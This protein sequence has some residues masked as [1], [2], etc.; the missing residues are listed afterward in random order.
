ML[1]GLRKFT[2]VLC[3]ILSKLFCVGQNSIVTE[4]LLPGN[5]AS[6]WDIQ[7][8]GDLS[9]QGFASTISVNKGEKVS[10]KVKTAAAAYT[11]K[12]YRLGFYQG[13]GARFI[14]TAVITASLPQLQPADLYDTATGMIDCGN[15]SVSAHWDVPVTAVSGIYIAKLTRNDTNGSSHIAFIVRDD[16]ANADILFKTADATWQAYNNYGGNSLYVNN[17]GIA[18]PGFNHA[19]KVS[20]NRPFYT[21]SGGG[22]G[23]AMED[24]LFNAEYPM[25][26]WLERNGYHVSYTTDADMDSLAEIITPLKHK[27]LLSVGH[28]EYWSA[29]MRSA[30]SNARNAGVHLAFFSGNEVY[31]KTRWGNNHRTLVCYKE[32]TQGE[33]VCGGKCDPIADVWTGLWR[34][35][36]LFTGADGCDAENA[37]TGQISW[38]GSTTS[39]QVP[40]V[41]GKHRFWRNTTVA[42]ASPGTTVTFPD[43]T[44][45]YE[46]DWEQQ[47]FKS[48]NPS[49]RMLLSSTT[50][51]GRTHKLSLYRHLSGALV[52][53]AGTVQWS[54]G[55]DN[56]HD[57]GN[58]PVSKDMQQ[59]TVNLLADMNV[60]PASIQSDLN[61]AALSTDT[62]APVSIITAPATG[63]IVNVGSVVSISGTSTDTVGM[64]AGIE[65]STDGGIT[66]NA[67]E[68]GNN[69]NYSWTPISTGTATIKVRGFDDSGNMEQS[70]N[71]V[72][73]TVTQPASTCPCTIFSPLDIPT[74]T[75]AN[76]GSAIEIGVRFRASTDGLIK[77]IRF[78][79][80]SADNGTHIAHLWTSNGISVASA[81][82]INETASGWQEVLFTNPVPISANTTYIASYH[83]SSGYY[84]YSNPYFT[85]PVIN[86]PLKGLANGEDGP[87]GLYKYT[88]LPDFPS[89]NFQSSN[90]W[91]DV[92]F[93]DSIVLDT[94]APL[95]SVVIPANNS[96]AALVTSKPTALFNEALD[97][98]TVNN[99]TFIIKD[100]N[101]N[102]IGG[103]VSYANNSAIFTPSI[104]FNYSATYTVTLKGGDS[105]NV[106]RDISAN[107]LIADYNWSFTTTAPPPPLPTEGTGGPI[108]I[109]SNASNPFSRYAVEI[110]RAEGLNEFDAIDITA[111]TPS[112][113]T[114]Y[115]VIILGSMPLS[116]TDVSMFSDWVNNGGTLITFKPDSS[117]ATLAGL[118][119]LGTTLS[120]KYI[121]INNSGPGKGI[122][123]QTIQFHG[124][125]DLYSLSGAQRI[126]ALYSSA[127]DSTV[128][129]A[130]SFKKT[131][132]TGGGV[133]SF[134][135]DL[136]RS[137]VYTR[138]GNPAWAGQSRDGQ[139]GPIRSNN[140]FFPDWIDFTK[141]AIPQ[142]DE[143]Q[144]LLA[145][146]IL[147]ANM[148]RKPLPKFWMLP[149]KLKAVIVMTGD[150]HGNGGTVG[151]FNQYLSYGNNTVQDVLDWRS[152]R[153][154]SYI[155]TSTNNSTTLTN[156]QAASFESQGFEISTH[157][158][159]NCDNWSSQQDLDNNF[160]TPQLNE[161][162]IK[163]PSVSA[164]T[165]NRTHCIAW[166][167]WASQAKVQAS[168]GIRLDAN[169]YYWPE[170]W[171]ANK[172]G[173]FTGSGMPMRFADTN[174]AL[175]D[176]YQMPTQMT[177]ETNMNYTAFTSSLLDKALGPEGYYGI[178]CANMHTDAGT[179]AGSDA[180]IAAAQSR[181]VPVISARQM[182]NWLD[183]RNGSHFDSLNWNGTQLAFNITTASGAYK[184]QAMLPVYTQKGQ[185][186]GIN[187]NGTPVNY[188]M[189]LIKGMNYAFFDALNGKYTASY[190]IDSVPP[191][192]SG[193]TATPNNNGTAILTWL[194]D[195]ASNSKIIYSAGPNPLSTVVSNDSLTTNHSLT[196]SNL[197]AGTRYYFRVIAEDAFNNSSSFPIAPDSLSFVMPLAPCINDDSKSDFDLGIAGVN[198]TVINE[199]SGSVILAPLLL[200]EFVV[201]VVPAGFTNEVWDGQPGAATSFNSGKIIL[202][203][204]HV[205]SNNSFAP[206]T[207]IEFQAI[208]S[209]GNFQN[210]GFSGDG[211]FNSP[212]ITIGR[213]GEGDGIVYARNA[214]GEK[215]SLGNNLLNAPHIYKIYWK[216]GTNNF[217]FYVDGILIATPQITFNTTSN[218]VVQLSDY[219]AGGTSL[220]IDWLKILPYHANGSYTSRVF[221]G[222]LVKKWNAVNWTASLPSGTS[223]EVFV[224]NGNTLLPDSSWTAYR[225][226]INSGDSA[227]A[228]SRFIQYQTVL[229]TT[230]THITPALKRVSVNCTPA[231]SSDLIPTITS[232]NKSVNEDDSLR[233]LRSHFVTNFMSPDIADSLQKIKITRLPA[234]GMLKM[235]GAAVLL[236]QEILINASDRL[237][238][239]PSLNYNGN[240]TIGWNAANSIGYA[241]NNAL[242]AI[243]ITAVNDLP[244]VVITAPVNGAVY[245]AGSTITMKVNATDIDG[246]VRKV[247]FLN[248]GIKFAEDSLA[249]YEITGSDLEPGVYVLT[250]NATDNL[251]AVKVSDTARVTITGCNPV[252]SIT[253]EGYTNI[254][255][256]QVADLL[257]NPNY[258]NSPSITV[259]LPVLEYNGVGDNYGA[260]LRGYIC[261]PQTGNY[262][263]YIAG[264]DQAGLWLS[265]NDNPANKVLI[266]YNELPVP[267]RGFT[268]YGTQKS[269]S[270]RLVK[271]VRYYIET[272]QKQSTLANHLSVAWVKPD[273]SI[274]APLPAR[275]L[276][277]ISGLPGV[278][279]GTNSDFGAAFKQT[280]KL[281]VTVAP[282]PS[283]N[284][285][286]LNIAGGNEPVT[287]IIRDVAGRVIK[288]INEQTTGSIRVG[289]ELR[290]G[291][292]FAELMQGKE[293][294]TIKLV[295]Q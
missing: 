188:S 260:R 111:I 293:K 266:A 166:S 39:L 2:I 269:A 205:Y 66:W 42:A 40:A 9:I 235:N 181:Q 13:N 239:Y 49:G 118:T 73:V 119:P 204:T 1:P 237:V 174:G 100:F 127:V 154:T 256:S 172:P 103:I 80:G 125:A 110:L 153:G 26:R 232:F 133:Y 67:I 179:S 57:R 131:G 178:F 53:G 207:A 64:I 157:I 38:E 43:G 68:G 287:I 223:I 145:N 70:A 247:E 222:G 218:M 65:I 54:W 129:P 106:I 290:A 52:F 140:L 136:A 225:K 264:D 253:G 212:W 158:N 130:V 190:S 184:L 177:D 197:S 240:D 113:L 150:D 11:I 10:F 122:V 47:A 41:Y 95:V 5:P 258:P 243:A 72:T 185:L 160:F 85:A 30:F 138:Q 6:E 282:N 124:T 213:G 16:A 96:S 163:W 261:A 173:M 146:I 75:N 284:Y 94:L 55:L 155:Y 112:L 116:P 294:I 121:L 251:G 161:F 58:T 109:I 202:D 274:D 208:F 276:S 291:V 199:D 259:Q 234:H 83:S 37:L 236:Q 278:N 268:I 139:S 193:V 262:T 292:Y 200:E 3:V 24:W 132:I 21:R 170:S 227:G 211:A 82:F 128:Y 137:I 196:L 91:V 187:F 279:S 248:Y 14:D 277:P 123:N 214:S 219:P 86:G 244:V 19:T 156:A 50:T 215:V 104:P 245:N 56:N 242:V 62:S 221:D 220:A 194:T 77:G 105:L 183:G 135:Y 141:I 48:K 230:N 192:I 148:H 143:Q 76:D 134:A 18:V 180:I 295:K 288:S 23:G 108:L 203:G 167:D 84:S 25:I 97:S 164:P 88:A 107:R 61:S 102:A 281:R 81:N 115:D 238:Y 286:T 280:R 89:Q 71:S 101:G 31:W 257:N 12:I 69:W 271:G 15:W 254:A 285:F 59:A 182:L 201:P 195:K 176:C 289:A 186:T 250:A 78:Y 159:T 209:S 92:I 29:K 99:N 252:G 246:S 46:W 63:Q 275:Y 229:S 34:D 152:I 267:F 35:G 27:V 191:V 151:R 117:L 175:I 249:P 206:G 169:Y 189:D 7:G 44:L 171:M 79:K 162:A 142:A 8:A 263:F 33:N 165:T 98:S 255:G 17:S 22:G 60:Q 114:S 28:D 149:R 224:R 233:L 20:Y 4:N 93:T 216:A 168:K 87:N 36:C 210:I 217:E 144:R 241:A 90:Y 231:D 45:G 283:N 126:A 270:V 120:D 265:T 51:G 32:G 228:L 272:L 147:Q 273:G 198:T 226:I 74:T